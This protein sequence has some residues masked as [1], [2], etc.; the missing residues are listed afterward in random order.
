MDRSE[1][2][3]K[4]T[5]R[6]LINYPD[7]LDF[8]ELCISAYVQGALAFCEEI[9]DQGKKDFATAQCQDCA[10]G[11]RYDEGW[12]DGYETGYEEGVETG[13]SSRDE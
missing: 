3:E 6:A 13:M 9:Y 4:A 7:G 10:S 1:L 2:T 5:R 8:R 12:G 11:E